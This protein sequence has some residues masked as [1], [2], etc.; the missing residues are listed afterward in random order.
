MAFTPDALRQKMRDCRERLVAREVEESLSIDL[1][2]EQVEER[3][4]DD[5]ERLRIHR[6]I[7][8][9][10]SRTAA[11]RRL[12]AIAI[13]LRGDGWSDEAISIAVRNQLEE[14]LSSAGRQLSRGSMT[15]Y[16]ELVPQD[17]W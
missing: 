11:T 7:K 13:T 10:I 12:R 2:S 14:D 17:S 5:H 3:E 4:F 9:D 6:T 8:R 16:A 15:R 1:V